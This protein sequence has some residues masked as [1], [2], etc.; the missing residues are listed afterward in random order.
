[1]RGRSLLILAFAL[2]TASS[3]TPKAGDTCRK[4]KSLCLDK[5]HALVCRAETYQPVQCAGALGCH[6]VGEEL[7]C[8][9]A[10]VGEGQSCLT[11]G[12]RFCARDGQSVVVCQGG[13]FA[14]QYDCRG[15]TGC[16]GEKLACDQTVANQGEPC[17]AHPDPDE[18]LFSCSLDKGVLLRCRLG[19]WEIYHFCRGPKA[20]ALRSP[21]I[22][23]CDGS[24]AQENDPCEPPGRVACADD[25][26]TELL[27]V[28]SSFMKSRRCPNGC[29]PTGAANAIRCE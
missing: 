28:G 16:S 11:E 25:H 22:P 27:C 10:Q 21:T 8:D 23:L 2:V 9:Q 1:M 4:G 7:V 5:A 12:R 29:N 6:K 15:A 17:Q 14:K 18:T 19:K 24:I 13:R 20:C 3:C 26:K